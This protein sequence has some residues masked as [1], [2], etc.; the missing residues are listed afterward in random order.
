MASPFDP[1]HSAVVSRIHY[2]ADR[3]GIP[4]SLAVWQIWQESRFDPRAISPA[5]ARGIAQFMPATAARFGVNVFDVES[6]LNGWGRY[7]RWLLD[8]P[9]IAG[10]LDLALAGYNAGEGRVKQAGGIPNIRETQNYVATIMANSGVA[11]GGI[12]AVAGSDDS[13]IYVLG[14]LAFALLV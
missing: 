3:Y 2:Y 8:Q 1:R 5:G 10:R 14:L 13:M 7:M 11:T 4:R 12:L 6:S 9:Y